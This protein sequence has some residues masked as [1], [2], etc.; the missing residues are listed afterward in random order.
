MNNFREL[1][2]WQL[3]IEIAKLVFKMTRNFPPDERYAL[4]AQ[5]TRASVS[6]S[7]NIAEG[8]SGK[9]KKEF[10]HFLS[11]GLG[12]AYELET[13]LILAYDFGYVDKLSFEYII[14]KINQ[15]ERMVGGLQKTSEKKKV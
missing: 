6:I 15:L 5:L 2:I 11:I 1:K 10:N 9:S 13:Q 12:S 7:S 14:P 8:C 3:S 4:T